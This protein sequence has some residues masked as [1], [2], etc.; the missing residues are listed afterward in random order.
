MAAATKRAG[1]E[2]TW[3]SWVILCLEVPEGGVGP[4]VEAHRTGGEQVQLAGGGNRAGNMM[5][6]KIE[7]LGLP[8]GKQIDS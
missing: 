2:W 5:N 1:V 3:R 7:K 4:G 8:P 6:L